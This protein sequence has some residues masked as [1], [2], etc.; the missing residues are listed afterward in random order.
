MNKRALILTV[1]FLL[2]AAAVFT[3]VGLIYHH[4][5]DD[6]YYD[7][8]QDIEKI[9]NSGAA[10]LLEDGYSVTAEELN[11]F[12]WDDLTSPAMLYFDWNGQTYRCGD[13]A[14]KESIAAVF[15]NESFTSFTESNENPFPDVPPEQSGSL[16]NAAYQILIVYDEEKTF[17]RICKRSDVSHFRIF[18]TEKNLKEE[19]ENVL[20][21]GAAVSEVITNP[22]EL[23]QFE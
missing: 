4:S 6:F 2:I 10:Y 16:N 17:L 20:G 5:E 1:V 19:M 18:V 21:K 8:S 12:L 22:Q 3:A 11:L 13:T 7:I 15:Q 23:T 9:E 14:A